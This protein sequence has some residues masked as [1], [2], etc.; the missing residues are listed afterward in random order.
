M[1]WNI[2]E[3]YENPGMTHN[4]FKLNANKRDASEKGS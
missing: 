1:T 4:F 2:V 3:L